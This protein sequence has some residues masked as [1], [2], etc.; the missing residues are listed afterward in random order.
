MIRSRVKTAAFITD[1][2]TPLQALRA[3]WLYRLMH[4][5][6]TAPNPPALK[7]RT[8][9]FRHS[10]FVINSRMDMVQIRILYNACRSTQSQLRAVRI[11]RFSGN[12]IC[13]PFF[14]SSSRSPRGMCG[15]MAD[16][17]SRSLWPVIASPR[18]SSHSLSCRFWRV[19]VSVISLVSSSALL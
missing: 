8:T 15:E 12:T 7:N 16:C 5:C 3:P 14:R 10:S 17:N 4:E 1:R 11:T 2:T 13:K 19:I 6:G 9:G 18:V